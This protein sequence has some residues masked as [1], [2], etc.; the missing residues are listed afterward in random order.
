MVRVRVTLR[1]MCWAAIRLGSTLPDLFFLCL[2]TVKVRVRNR[3]GI[4]VTFCV[5][6]LARFTL[7]G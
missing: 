1:V 7:L 2:D 5:I 3:V 4:R 6:V